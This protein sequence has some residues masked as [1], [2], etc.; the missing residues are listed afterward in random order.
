[1]KCVANRNKVKLSLYANDIIVH[2]EKSIEYKNQKP[3]DEFSKFERY[4]S[5]I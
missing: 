5:N 4:K 1:M 3:I 2:I